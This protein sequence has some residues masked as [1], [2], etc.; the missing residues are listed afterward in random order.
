MEMLPFD[1]SKVTR[2]RRHHHHHHHHCS[3]GSYQPRD[4]LYS[5]NKEISRQENE[6]RNDIA[7]SDPFMSVQSRDK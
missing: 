1:D 3:L 2:R 6:E 7:V 4:S 5:A